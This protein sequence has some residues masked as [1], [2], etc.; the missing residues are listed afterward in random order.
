MCFSSSSKDKCCAIVILF[1]FMMYLFCFYSCNGLM[2]VHVYAMNRCQRLLKHAIFQLL[3]MV[4]TK[5]FFHWIQAAFVLLCLLDVS[6]KSSTHLTIGSRCHQWTKLCMSL[7]HDELA[8]GMNSWCQYR[9]CVNYLFYIWV[10]WLLII[11][12]Q[13]E[14]N[15][16]RNW[17]IY[18]RLNIVSP[19]V[20]HSSS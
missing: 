11:F 19:K 14:F 13:V 8:L 2:F 3:W 9:I 5:C 4:T 15:C 7:L 20:M 17:I 10:Y 18:L 12:S 1:K 6:M 16:W